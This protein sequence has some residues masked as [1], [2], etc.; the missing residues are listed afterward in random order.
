MNI[1]KLFYE[2][3]DFLH[4]AKKLYSDGNF[5]LVETKKSQVWGKE[6]IEEKWELLL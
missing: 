3:I 1:R 6:L 2:T 4:A 5:K